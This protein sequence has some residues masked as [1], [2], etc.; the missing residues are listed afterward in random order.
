[1]IRSPLL[2]LLA[3]LVLVSHALALAG[4]CDCVAPPLEEA[5]VAMSS[6]H[7]E[8]GL[9]ISRP[10]ACCCGDEQANQRGDALAPSVGPGAGTAPTSLASPAPPATAEF[11]LARPVHVMNRRGPSLP[12]PPLRV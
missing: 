9:R 4:V 10:A 8:N 1:M 5:G 7:E 3:G 6:C 11:A 2:R 12:R